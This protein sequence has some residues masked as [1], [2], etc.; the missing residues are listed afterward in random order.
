MSDVIVVGAGLAG[1]SAAVALAQG[2]A[3]VTLL[4]RRP[5]IGGRAYSYDHPALEE[6]IDSQHVVVGCCTNL[7]DLARQAW[8]AETIRWYDDLV[9]LESNGRRSLLR[10]T[11][12][13]AP[14]HRA[15]S[16]LRAPMLG[17]ADKTAIA[18]GLLRFLRG[19]PQ[20][21][22]ESFA[23]WLK[24][25][26]QT[27]RAIRHFWEPVIVGALNDTFDRCSVK[28]A[29]KVFHESFLRS[30]EAGRLGIPAAPLTE[31]FQPIVALAE[32]SGVELQLKCGVEAIAQT[33]DGRWSVRTNGG[34]YLADSVVLA[35][36]FRQTQ[37]L[38][39]MLPS[40]NG[41]RRLWQEGFE[42]FVPSPITTIHLW[43]DRDVTGLDHAVL[44]DARIQWV[45]T[46][47][48]IRRWTEERG[49]YQ[50]LVI[51]ASWPE[52]EMSREEILSSATREFEMFFPAARQA[53]LVKSGVLKEARAT[54]SVTP[55]LDRFRPQQV[56][57][58]K[59]L[60]LAGDWTATEWPSTMEGAIRS[61]RLAAGEIAGD[62]QRFMVPEL[63][64]A[65]LMKFL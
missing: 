29:G 36:D 26:G 42:R 32:R 1:L 56:T 27:E 13:P 61:G 16:F 2:G 4:E 9:F 7:L 54:F 46:K 59:G 23:S 37:K 3:R 20:N 21:D 18:S 63:P 17:L 24:R 35:T 51:S 30:Q 11:S 10:S 55:G 19:F 50:E 5:Y 48:R 44:L 6:T 39:D 15:S 33:P 64:A 12:L 34:E 62:R 14:L 43:Y 28:Y 53:K 25:T 31:F 60:F 40:S 52:L 57:H 8:M 49:S 45:F 65:G 58:W 41:E 47:S 38:L 22:S